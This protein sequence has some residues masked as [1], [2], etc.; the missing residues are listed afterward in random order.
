MNHP[1]KTSDIQDRL[2]YLY[3]LDGKGIKP[4]LSR[5]CAFLDQIGKPHKKLKTIHVAGTNGKGSTCALIASV[6]QAAGYSVGLY[7]SPHLV[8]F[9]ERIRINGRMISDAEIVAFLDEKQAIIDKLDT[10]F[11]ETTTSMAFDYFVK[12]KVDIV[13]LEAGLGGRLDATNVVTPVI[14][15]ITAIG[16]DHE[17]FLGHTLEKITK[18]KAGIMKSGVPAISAKQKSVSKA[19]L[20][21]EAQRKNCPFIYSPDYCQIRSLGHNFN[22]QTVSITSRGFQAEELDFPFLGDHQLFN[23]STAITVLDNLKCRAVNLE[24]IINGISSTKW[25]G[26]LEMLSSEPYIYY[27]VG[28]NEH[29]IRQVARTLAKLFPGEKIKVLL[30]LGRSKK[31]RSLGRILSEITDEIYV[32]EIPNGKSFSAAVL[33]ET[34][35][36]SAGGVKI[37]V[38]PN[39]E[40]ALGNIVQTLHKDDRLLILGSHY[41]AA[42]IYDFFKIIV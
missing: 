8:R 9:N 12:N 32:S 31:V 26:R 41:F 22:R 24:S 28:H 13:V 18:E 29:G 17:E 37:T 36:S 21:D 38:E 1:Q 3:A 15:V 10:T 42:I 40:K 39:L 34:L 14:S 23:L 7:T 35:Q 30:A 27:D 25:H 11:F 20:Q 33:A 16:K 2:N 19:I 4:G 5:V 6:L